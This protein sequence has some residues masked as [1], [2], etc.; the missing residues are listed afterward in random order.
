MNPYEYDESIRKN[1]FGSVAGVDE[2]GRGPL[3]GPVVAAAVILPEDFRVEGVRDSK[4]IPRKEREELFWAI[5]LNAR[6]IGIGIIDQAEIDRLNIL[7]ATKL[8][9]HNALTDLTTKPDMILIDAL[10]IPSIPIK[11][12]PIIKG[13]AKSASIAAASII[14]KVVRDGIMIEYHSIYPSYEFDKHKGYA[15]KAHLDKIEK[16]G[17]CPIHRKTFHKVKDLLLPF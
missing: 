9:M 5:V 12:I 3:A 15:T 6:S 4:K 2:A 17:P 10:T 7:R 11:Q 13:D 16:H 8:A 1:G 14:A